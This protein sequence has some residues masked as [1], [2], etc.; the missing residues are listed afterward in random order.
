MNPNRKPKLHVVVHA[1]LGKN[2]F[3]HA[4]HMTN[5]A[6]NYGADSVILIPD[7]TKGAERKPN[8]NQ[9]LHLYGSMKKRITDFSI[10][11]NPLHK[12]YSDEELTQIFKKYKF[13]S[14]QSDGS[15]AEKSVVA[16][17]PDSNFFSA[18]A[19]KYSKDEQAPTKRLVELCKTY[20][21]KPKNLI[22]TTS[23]PATGIPADIEKIR[24]IVANLNG[25][26]LG[27][28]SGITI[29]NVRAYRNIGVTD[30][31]VATS[32]LD[33]VDSEG[34]DI[35]CPERIKFLSNIVHCNE[36]LNHR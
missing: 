29:E 23:G 20:D 11:I 8:P 32:L 34:Y 36:R 13:H 24:T 14:Y 30:F 15:I 25:R 16:C 27:I 1:L 35:L 6:K 26:R 4:E 7:Y 18:I 19:F 10:G 9:I 28:A 5:I 2:F 21:G 17:N 3:T 33:H 22:P 31:I 12:G